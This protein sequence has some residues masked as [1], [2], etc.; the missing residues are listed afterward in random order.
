MNWD[1]L[2]L[3][4]RVAAHRSMS[5]ASADVRLSVATIG[6]RL[7]ALERQIGVPLLHR[8]PRGF[9][10]TEQGTALQRRAEA[11]RLAM[12]EVAR[13]AAT[14]G[15]KRSAPA[16]RISATEPVISEI[17][18]AR[19]PMLLDKH[20]NLRLTLRVETAVVSLPLNDADIAI[21]LVRPQGDSLMAKRLRPLGMGLFGHK[22][23][24]DADDEP[25][26]GTVPIIGYDDTYGPLPELRWLEEADLADQVRIRTSSTRGMVNAVA[27]GA[28]LAILPRIFARELP[29]VVE[30]KPRRS[31]PIADRSIW[32]VWHR[33]MTR[34][35]GMRSVIAW[36]E[37][38]FRD[39]A[40]PSRPSAGKASSS[41]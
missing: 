24:L 17:L 25:D 3:F 34:Q 27:A 14:L 35:P 20:P 10:L 7:A 15:A 39:A 31:Q 36:I 21:R 22:A 12:A 8:T 37:A 1:D 6:R 23:L 40:Y 30:V 4:L 26:W 13:F 18:M 11:S 29:D 16:I 38:C 2:D 33:S 32:I 19:L 9:I 41:Q 28:G 5:A